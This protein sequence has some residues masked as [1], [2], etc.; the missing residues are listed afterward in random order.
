MLFL[1]TCAL[2]LIVVFSILSGSVLAADDLP[3]NDLLDRL[4]ASVKEDQPFEL[5]VRL[6][7]KPGT[8]A[9][10]AA[11]AAKVAKATA[12]EPGN[13]M[14]V[15]FEHLEQPG[16]VILFEKWKNIAALKSHLEQPHTI[17]WLKFTGDIGV[18]ATIGILGPLGA[19]KSAP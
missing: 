15:F 16:T 9:K 18:Q 19:A 3:A 10:F 6:K 2:W 13:E 1:R 8:E 4:K 17:P 7:L 11:E 5:L 14:F 12:A